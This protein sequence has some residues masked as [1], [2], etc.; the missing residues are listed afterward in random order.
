MCANLDAR[1]K[2]LGFTEE[3]GATI[4]GILAVETMAQR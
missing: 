2:Q 1:A 4:R 3:Q